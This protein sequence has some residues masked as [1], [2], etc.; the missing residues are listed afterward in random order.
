MLNTR[1]ISYICEYLSDEDIVDFHSTTHF[2]PN[3]PLWNERKLDAEESSEKAYYY[4]LN[5]FKVK[6]IVKYNYPSVFGIVTSF[7]RKKRLRYE[8]ELRKER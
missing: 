1:I 3:I 7:G 8:R 5:N 4:I 6:H 2:N